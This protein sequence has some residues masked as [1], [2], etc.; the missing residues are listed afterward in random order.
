MSFRN[1]KPFKSNRGYIRNRPSNRKFNRNPSYYQSPSG[2]IRNLYNI[3]HRVL[4]AHIA[5]ET[6]SRNSIFVY[7]I[8]DSFPNYLLS[9]CQTK[10]VYQQY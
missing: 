7:I 6:K 2:I 4:I 8:V 1:N 10:G 5:A 3:L 9:L